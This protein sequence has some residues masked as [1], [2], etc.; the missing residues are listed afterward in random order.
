M[1]YRIA[2]V[3]EHARV[4]V[5]GCVRDFHAAAVYLNVRIRFTWLLI[6]PI[7]HVRKNRYMLENKDKHE[8]TIS[9]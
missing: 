9:R 2:K 5:C 7:F 4:C 3:H 8:K 6:L 1:T